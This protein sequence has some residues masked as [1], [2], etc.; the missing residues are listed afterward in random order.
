MTFDSLHSCCHHYSLSVDVK[1]N[2]FSS[3]KDQNVAAVAT[4]HCISMLK[5]WII[6]YV[7]HMFNISVT[8]SVA[9]DCITVNVKM[10]FKYSFKPYS[11][12]TEVFMAIY[13]Y[14][15]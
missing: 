7:V 14:A 1:Y 2:F 8:A 9:T 12:P 10:N 11:Y 6:E 4:M 15:M 5:M 3:G 13:L